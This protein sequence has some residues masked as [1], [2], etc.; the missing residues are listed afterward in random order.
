MF[1]SLVSPCLFWI[2]FGKCLRCFVEYAHFCFEILSHVGT[3]LFLFLFFLVF[4]V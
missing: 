4:I 3:F 2:G 1:V